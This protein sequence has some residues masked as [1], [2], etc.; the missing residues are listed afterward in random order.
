[1]ASV[2]ISNSVNHTSLPIRPTYANLYRWPESDAEFMKKICCNVTHS[3]ATVVD[4]LSC[5]QMYLRSYTF[6][7]KKEGITG[8]TR[9]CL[10]RVSQR[11]VFGCGRIG[12]YYKRLKKE[13]LM[14]R[15]AKDVFCAA[16]FSMFSWLLS[17]F[18]KVQRWMRLVIVQIY[19]P[20]FPL[21][22]PY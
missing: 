10:S 20:V 7:R 14:L 19:S 12:S 21:Q 1:M 15:R 3:Q 9:K 5:R 4:S 8:K 6:S 16:L 2:C 18:A 22:L 13:Y 11:V 17:C